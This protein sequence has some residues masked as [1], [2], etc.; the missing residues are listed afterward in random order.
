MLLLGMLVLK[1]C[2]LLLLRRQRWRQRRRQRLLRLLL[3][4]M[5]SIVGQLL[6]LLLGPVLGLVLGLLDHQLLLCHPRLG[7]PGRM[8][9]LNVRKEAP[10]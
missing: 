2:L 8:S 4:M 3:G 1:H 9:R 5:V 10:N 7:D 6:G